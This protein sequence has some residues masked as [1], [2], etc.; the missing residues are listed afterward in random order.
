MRP[1]LVRKGRERRGGR[2]REGGEGR[3][4]EG[5]KGEERVGGKKGRENVSVYKLCGVHNQL[6]RV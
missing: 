2:K 1:H 3:K 5:E 6:S 4:E